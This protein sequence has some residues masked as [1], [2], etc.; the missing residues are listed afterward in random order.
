MGLDA[1]VIS[2]EFHHV[3]FTSDYKQRGVSFAGGLQLHHFS[4]TMCGLISLAFCLLNILGRTTVV[5]FGSPALDSD[6]ACNPVPHIY[7]HGSLLD[8]RTA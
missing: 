1:L 6:S 4:R 8:R 2:D 7:G 5:F 3:D